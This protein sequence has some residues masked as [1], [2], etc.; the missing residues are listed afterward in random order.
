MLGTQKHWLNEEMNERHIGRV[1]CA[2]KG[3]FPEGPGGQ[4]W[5][6]MHNNIHYSLV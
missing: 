6:N 2:K 1:P 4:G 5:M 3:T